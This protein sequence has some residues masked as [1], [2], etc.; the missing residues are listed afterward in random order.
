MNP[1]LQDT[2]NEFLLTLEEVDILLSSAEK[3]ISEE[4][5]YA[6]YNKSALLLLS[7]KFE[8]FVELVAEEY[9]FLV[10]NL[11]LRSSLLPETIKL[12]HTYSIIKQLDKQLERGISL[13][14][15][16]TIT[17]LLNEIGQIWVL[18]AAFNKLNINCKFSYG[19]HGEKE[20]VKLFS[21]LGISDIFAEV[22]VSIP[23]ENIGNEQTQKKVD[24]KGIFNSV[25]NMRNN[26]L[27][28]NASPS[29]THKSVRDYKFALQGFAEAVCVVLDNKLNLLIDAA[30]YRR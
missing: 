19:K 27:H 28:Q 5:K 25:M 8:N 7:G 21:P 17:R 3:S 6:T 12:N 9:I 20:L 26:I 29:L 14:E 16:G 10:N 18:D 22:E 23:D 15:S 24:V 1:E 2:L 13:D 30:N 4:T 11:N